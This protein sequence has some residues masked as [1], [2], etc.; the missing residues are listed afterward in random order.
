MDI[1]S[2]LSTFI[3]ITV[4]TLIGNYLTHYTYD[5]LFTTRCLTRTHN[6]ASLSNAKAL[7]NLGHTQLLLN[8]N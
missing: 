8:T 4:H 5:L 2:Y 1:Y 3:D 7:T 6:N